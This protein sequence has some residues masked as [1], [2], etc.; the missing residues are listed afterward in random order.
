LT[1]EGDAF[2]VQVEK[3]SLKLFPAVGAVAAAFHA[4]AAA[5]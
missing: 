3:S 2:N 5:F 1:A 4:V